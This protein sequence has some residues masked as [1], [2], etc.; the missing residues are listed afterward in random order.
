MET[1]SSRN[2]GLEGQPYRT[3]AAKAGVALGMVNWVMGEL[4]EL[5]F[6]VEV[7]EGRAG[8]GTLDYRLCGAAPAQT[9]SWPLIAELRGGDRTRVSKP[10]KALWVCKTAGL[11][12]SRNM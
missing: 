10:E 5:G 11:K 4:K 7:G 6:L 8:T 2:P 1:V 3:I 9:D 12:T